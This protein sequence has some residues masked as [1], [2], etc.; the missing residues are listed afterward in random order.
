MA[1]DVNDYAAIRR[2]LVKSGIKPVNG[3][4]Y[5]LYECGHSYSAA[6]DPARM[7]KYGPNYKAIRSCPKCKRKKVLVKYKR[8]NCGIEQT[9]LKVQSSKYCSSCSFVKQQ[10][11]KLSKKG[12]ARRNKHLIDESRIHCIHR[13]T[14]LTKYFDYE[15]VPCKGCPDYIIE[16]AFA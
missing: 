1:I 2:A 6:D 13:N 16:E 4:A 11:Q 3:V 8:C 9:G 5:F 14:C 12:K 7:L 15:V 10:L